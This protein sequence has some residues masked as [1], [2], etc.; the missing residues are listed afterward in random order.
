MSK[1]D[2]EYINNHLVYGTDEEKVIH[3]WT[4]LY[5]KRLVNDEINQIEE[6]INYLKEKPQGKRAQASIW[7]QDKDLYGDIGPCLQ[8]LWFQIVENRLELHVHMRASDAYGKLLMNI[9]EF[10]ALQR[11]VANELGIDTGKYYQF[12]DTCHINESDLEKVSK[13]IPQL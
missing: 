4:K 8:I 10:C 9:N 2:I 6:I 11:F 12:V 1:T 13:I 5:R 7:Q 3:D